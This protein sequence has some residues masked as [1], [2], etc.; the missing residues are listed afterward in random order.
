[1]EIASNDGY[2]LQECRRSGHPRTRHRA[3]RERGRGRHRLGG[4]HRGVFLR[5]QGGRGPGREAWP[6]RSR[7]RQQRPRTRARPQRLR[8]GA[9]SVGRR[10]RCDLDRGATSARARAAPRVRHDLPRALL[11]LLTAR[12]H[13]VLRA[14]RSR[15]LRRRGTDDPRGQPPRVRSIGAVAARAEPRCLAGHRGGAARRLDEPAGFAAFA[16]RSEA[17]RDGLVA[18]LTGLR[19]A[20]RSIAAYGAAAKG[21]TLL[22]FADVHTD[23]LP[24]VVDRNPH[25]QGLLL[26]GSHLPIR[27][28]AALVDDRPDYVLILPWNLSRRDHRADVGCERAGEAGSSWRCQRY[29]RSRDLPRCRPPGSVPRRPG[30]SRRRAGLVRADVLR[31]RVRAR[32]PRSRDRAMQR[33][34]K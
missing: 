15:G 29:G 33:V 1:M 9:R 31:G 23:L 10:R 17:C 28:P 26:P 18:F 32:G 16:E 8:R 22:N 2:L 5:A 7:R 6:R 24:Y 34:S 27:D 21:N 30:A 19:S 13:R 25:K 20:G 11:V 14:P 4:S 3:S 12:A